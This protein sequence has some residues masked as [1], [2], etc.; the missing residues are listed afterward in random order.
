MF[1]YREFVIVVVPENVEI[2]LDLSEPSISWIPENVDEARIE[3]GFLMFVIV[4]EKMP[5]T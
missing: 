1:A 3:N 5:E 2:R 4:N